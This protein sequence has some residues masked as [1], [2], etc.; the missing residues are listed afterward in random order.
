MAENIKHGDWWHLHLL[1]KLHCVRGQHST[2]QAG[3]QTEIF[4]PRLSLEM[5]VSVPL[6]PTLGKVPSREVSGK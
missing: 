2:S 4:T 3:G 5:S 1:R 6:A